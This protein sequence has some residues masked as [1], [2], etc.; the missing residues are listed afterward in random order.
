V[1]SS[2]AFI[3]YELVR[4]KPSRSLGKLDWLPTEL[5]R[6]EEE[7]KREG[8]V[9][10]AEKIE[11]AREKA[12]GLI[13]QIESALEG[14]TKTLDDLAWSE[15]CG[16][17]REE[18]CSEITVKYLQGRRALIECYKKNIVA[19]KEV[20]SDF[21]N[22][23]PGFRAIEAVYYTSSGSLERNIFLYWPGREKKPA[24]LDALAVY[25]KCLG[26][27]VED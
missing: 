25:E 14:I 23:E 13:R 8:L 26:I 10:L 3:C 18:I 24:R 22:L 2:P 19:C 12:E 5:R 9:E 1:S 16:L 11:E 27:K 15:L 17:R 6:L 7:A 21:E 20:T 4:M